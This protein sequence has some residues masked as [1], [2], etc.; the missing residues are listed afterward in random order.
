MAYSTVFNPMSYGAHGD[1]VF[2]DAPYVQAAIDAAQSFPGGVVD[3]MG[4]TFAVGTK[5]NVG[6]GTN[7]YGITLQNM[8]L[9]A[10][11]GTWST[12]VS[13]P[14]DSTVATAVLA[15]RAPLLQATSQRPPTGRRWTTYL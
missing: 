3:G 5:I 15:I 11:A 4:N 9:K 12:G 2:N 8:K 10:I 1:G 13:Y 14:D 6:G 7:T